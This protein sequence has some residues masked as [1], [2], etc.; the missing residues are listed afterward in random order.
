MPS[1]PRGH[2]LIPYLPRL[3]FRNSLVGPG[4]LLLRISIAGSRVIVLPALVSAAAVLG[5]LLAVLIRTASHLMP[6]AALA[7]LAAGRR[8]L[9]VLGARLSI[10]FSTARVRVFARAAGHRCFFVCSGWAVFHAGVP[11]LVISGRHL[12]AARTACL[13]IRGGRFLLRCRSWRW[14]CG[15]SPGHQTQ[16]QEKCDEFKLHKIGLRINGFCLWECVRTTHV[17]VSANEY[18]CAPGRGVR[19]ETQIR[20]TVLNAA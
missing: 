9:V 3:V 17:G 1:L 8:R 20:R 18:L 16:S 6:L 10:F 7:F 15:L 5:H 14:G 11:I 2:L 13:A 12:V 19:R 4:L